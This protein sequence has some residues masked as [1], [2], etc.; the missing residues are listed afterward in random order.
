MEDKHGPL[1]THQIEGWLKEHP[2]GWRARDVANALDIKNHQASVLLRYL[3]SKDRARR[4]RF[5]EGD[6]FRY[7]LWSYK[8]PGER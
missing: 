8:E 5:I 1:V 7:S 6:G 4:E 2:G 3:W